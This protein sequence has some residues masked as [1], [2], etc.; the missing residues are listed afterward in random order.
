MTK[1]KRCLLKNYFQI[2]ISFIF[3]CYYLY[4]E[5]TV[6]AYVWLIFVMSYSNSFVEN[7]MQ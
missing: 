7:E 3:S 4:K 2:D 5:I 6:K 1:T